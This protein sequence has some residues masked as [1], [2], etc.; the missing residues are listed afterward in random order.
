MTR[1]LTI[2]TLLFATPAWAEYEQP[3][4]NLVFQQN[5]LEIRDY[6]PAVVVETQVVASRRDAAGD[7]FRSLFNYISGNNDASLEI[8]MTSPVAQTYA[9]R[10]RDNVSGKWAV[11]FFLPRDLS[12]EAIPEPLQL[13]VNIV[14]L[15]AQRFA[16]VSFKG[17]QNDKKVAKNSARLREFIAQNGYRVSG[18]PVY[19]F[20]D[21]P[22]VPW[23]LRDNEILFPIEKAS[24]K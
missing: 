10:E 12:A 21:P 22:F 15:G 13:G 3:S 20:Y 11:R 19:A 8:P 23:F 14:T 17:T 9:G 24:I 6:A 16:S 5:G 4:Y 7:A 18:Q 1:I 2:I